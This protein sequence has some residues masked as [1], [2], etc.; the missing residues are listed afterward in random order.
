MKS[1]LLTHK[2][3]GCLAAMA[4]LCFFT[5]P[6]QAE[7]IGAITLRVAAATPSATADSEALGE[8][9]LKQLKIRLMKAN[10]EGNLEELASLAKEFSKYGDNPR[11]G[12]VA[13]YHAGFAQYVLALMVGPN[14]LV[15]PQGDLEQMYRH[16]DKA[17]AQLEVSVG[18]SGAAAESFALLSNLYAMKLRSDPQ[19]LGAT[20][21]PKSREM[22]KKAVE[23]AP[24]NPRVVLFNAMRTFWT[25]VSFGGDRSKGITLW[26]RAIELFEK[27]AG[28]ENSVLPSWGHAEALAWIQAAYLALQPPKTAEAERAVRKALEIRP[29]YKWVRV[30]VVPTM[31]AALNKNE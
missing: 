28:R 31:E 8:R 19:K 22:L 24:E 5:W 3:P 27:E 9:D 13:H 11:T 12:W 25:P 26:E 15:S 1:R 14:G 4:W 29:D 6:A 20:L 16:V 21:G 10:Y 18:K 23:L 7:P 17:I 2:L 30:S